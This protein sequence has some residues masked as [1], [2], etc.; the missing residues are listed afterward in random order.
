[1]GNYTI[2]AGNRNA[3]NQLKKSE[4]NFSKAQKLE[5]TDIADMLIKTVE[6]LKKVIF[7]IAKNIHISL[8]LYGGTGI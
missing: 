3:D 1:M 7:L 6:M 5:I 2:S 4:Q 8:F